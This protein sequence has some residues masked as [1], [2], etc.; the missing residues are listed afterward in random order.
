[1][2]GLTPDELSYYAEG[3]A[4]IGAGHAT[5]A[6]VTRDAVIVLVH[7]PHAGPCD[8]V[9]ELPLVLEIPELLEIAAAMLA[10]ARA[11]RRIS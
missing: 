8:D 6:G 1:V 9:I 3:I 2:R 5:A 4:E 7:P 10:R 11:L